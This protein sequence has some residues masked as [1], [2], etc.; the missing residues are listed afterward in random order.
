MWLALL[1]KAGK[2]L[3]NPFTWIVLLVV[4]L[5]IQTK[6]VGLAQAEADQIEAECAAAAESYAKAKSDEV[7]TYLW[8]VIE[9]QRQALIN[10]VT[11][12]AQQ[13]AA[14]RYWEGKYAEALKTPACQK[15]ASAPVLC[16]VE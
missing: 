4:A 11:R 13:E 5:G 8:G 15:W 7:A 12:E 16:P 14:R 3:F 2:L 9:T 10:A 6:R 1:A